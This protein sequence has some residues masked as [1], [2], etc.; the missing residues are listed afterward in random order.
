MID[1]IQEYPPT[2]QD[3]AEE[4]P[5]LAREYASVAQA[6]MAEGRRV[7]EGLRYQG[8]REGSGHRP[9]R[10]G[11]TRMADQTSMSSRMSVPANGHNNGLVGSVTG[12]GQ[13]VSALVELQAKL[14]AIDTKESAEKAV[15]PLV[16][17][18]PRRSY[19][20]R[21]RSRSAWLD[22]RRMWREHCSSRRPRA[23]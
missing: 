10:G 12:F 22:S 2:Y 1:R 20:F 21:P 8:T 7:R 3:Q 11:R 6:R 4:L 15:I 16:A 19:S 9:W 23:C 17:H 18:L 14:V 13:D 5:A